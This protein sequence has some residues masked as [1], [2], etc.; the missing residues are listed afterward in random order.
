MDTGSAAG[1]QLPTF[2][3]II[4]VKLLVGGRLTGLVSQRPGASMGAIFAGG[5][6]ATAEQ[7][8]KD[9]LDEFHRAN[10]SIGP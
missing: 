6:E 7:Q 5:N 9:E 4:A 1:F 3:V 8:G 2:I 10:S